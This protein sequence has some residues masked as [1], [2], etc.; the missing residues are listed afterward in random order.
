MD[1]H[2][3]IGVHIT[4]RLKEVVEVQKLLSKY[5]GNIKTRL[6][7]HKVDKVDSVEGVLI[8]EMHGEEMVCLELADRLHEVEGVETGKIVFDHV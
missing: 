2:I 4:N 7:L 1:K 6:G 8:L 5:G 3:I